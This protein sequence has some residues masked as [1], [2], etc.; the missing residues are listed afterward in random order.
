MAVY[1]DVILRQPWRIGA[2]LVEG[3]APAPCGIGSTL[4]PAG[5]GTPAGDDIVSE[6]ASDSGSDCLLLV[7]RIEKMLSPTQPTARQ[8]QQVLAR[9]TRFR[10]GLTQ[11]CSVRRVVPE[12]RRTAKIVRTGS[13]SVTIAASSE[14]VP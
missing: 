11:P 7:H 8:R 9:S 13:P 6:G 1:L 3:L 5:S 10:H 2:A 12:L 14:A 4:S